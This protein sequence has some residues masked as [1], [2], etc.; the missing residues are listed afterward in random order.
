VVNVGSDEET[1][2]NELAERVRGRV[3]PQAEI[4]H[5]PYNEAY[6]EGFEDPRRRVPDLSRL[7]RLTGFQPAKTLDDI[8]DDVAEECRSRKRKIDKL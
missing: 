1:S 7:K 3:N 6:G 5:V 8:I 4:V 2:I